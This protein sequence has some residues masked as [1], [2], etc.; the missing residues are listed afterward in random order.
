MDNETL[1]RIID[2]KDKHQSCYYCGETRSVKY[3]VYESDVDKLVSCC[4]LCAIYHIE[5]IQ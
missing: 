5:E 4:N 3:D 2:W 1:K